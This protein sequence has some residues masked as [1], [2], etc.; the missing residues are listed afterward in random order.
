MFIDALVITKDVIGATL[1]LVTDFP[2]SSW[3]YEQHITDN[4]D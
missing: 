2:S 3:S 1:P 4:I